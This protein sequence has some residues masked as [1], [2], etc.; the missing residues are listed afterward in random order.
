MCLRLLEQLIVLLPAVKYQASIL[1]SEIGYTYFVTSTV[2]RHIYNTQLHAKMVMVNHGLTAEDAD[3]LL[4]RVVV[5]PEINAAFERI[6]PI[7]DFRK[8]DNEARILYICRRVKPDGQNGNVDG[9]EDL[10][11]LKCKVQ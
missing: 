9:A 7:T 1:L 8:D 4:D 11:I 6:R 5:F 2:L 10:Y 3:G